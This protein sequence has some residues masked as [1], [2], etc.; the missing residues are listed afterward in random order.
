V[1]WYLEEANSMTRR[2]VFGFGFLVFCNE[3]E[4]HD[5]VGTLGNDSIP[6]EE[7]RPHYYFVVGDLLVA[8]FASTFQALV[9]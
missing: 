9:A 3:W 2:K 7:P 8:V 4:T 5:C 1:F 6:L